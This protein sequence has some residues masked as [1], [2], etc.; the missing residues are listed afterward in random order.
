MLNLSRLRLREVS[1]DSWTVWLFIALRLA[2]YWARR[3]V[4][5]CKKLLWLA[6]LCLFFCVGAGLFLWWAAARSG[7]GALFLC[8]SKF[9]QYKNVV[10]QP[11]TVGEEMGMCDVEHFLR[12]LR[13][14]PSF[15][16]FVFL[17]SIFFWLFY[18]IFIVFF[19]IIIIITFSYFYVHLL[20]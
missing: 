14:L 16:I 9:Y 11:F 5:P 1:V 15:Y 7:E 4:G 3:A 6:A 8:L 12:G 17:F 18:F 19:I 2:H 20:F 10:L 13:V